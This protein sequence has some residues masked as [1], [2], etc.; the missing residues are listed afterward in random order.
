MLERTNLMSP[1]RAAALRIQATWTPATVPPALQ[2]GEVHVWRVHIDDDAWPVDQLAA[3]LSGEESERA[4]RFKFDY[5]Q[6]R[7]KITHGILRRLLAGY[8]GI[9]PETPTLDIGVHGKP[10]LSADIGTLQF[11]ISDSNGEALLAFSMSQQLGVD[12]EYNRDDIHCLEVAERF[13]CADEIAALKSYPAEQLRRVFFRGWT[14]K[15]SYMK[16]TGGGIASGVDTFA[17][18]LAPDTPALLHADDGDL[19]WTMSNL[20]DIPDFS[21][22]LC[23]RPEITCVRYFMM[24]P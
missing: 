18:S 10:S 14:R 9:A 15:E 12:L 13:F 6:R 22:A 20:P 23:V 16:A 4:A 5:L 2:A 3:A 7:F 8:L 17:V 19:D 24:S 21:S 1:D 11:N